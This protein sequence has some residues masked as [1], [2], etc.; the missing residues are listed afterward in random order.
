MTGAT[1]LK[2]SPSLIILSYSPLPSDQPTQSLVI[3]EIVITITL[4][5]EMAE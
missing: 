4:M 5:S 3:M 2:S 1:M